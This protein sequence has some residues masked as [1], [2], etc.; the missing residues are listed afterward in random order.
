[1]TVVWMA[2]T[3][4]VLEPLT[5]KRLEQIANITVSC[6][7][8]A[9]TVATA[10]TIINMV[11]PATAAQPASKDEEIEGYGRQIVQKAVSGFE[12]V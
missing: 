12:N 11:K 10:D 3:L 5:P 4:P 8:T 1:M 7:Y 9:V 2:F 6:L